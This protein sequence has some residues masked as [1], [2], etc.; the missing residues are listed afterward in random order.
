MIPKTVAF[1]P[2]PDSLLS[3]SVAFCQDQRRFITHL[4]GRRYLWFFCPL[5]TMSNKHWC[6]PSEYAPSTDLA[7]KSAERRG[8]M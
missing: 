6:L 4:N 7:R 2:F 3:R 1:A 5:V 8:S